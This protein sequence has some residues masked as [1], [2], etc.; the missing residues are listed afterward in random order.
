[1]IREGMAKANNNRAL[2][3][4]TRNVAWN[5]A[6]WGDEQRW[7]NGDHF[8]HRW[9]GGTYQRSSMA[10]KITDR[11]LSPYLAGRYELKILEIAP[12]GGRFTTELIRRA[13]K[14]VLVDLN[15]A[16][17][18]ICRERFKYYNNHAGQ[19]QFHVNDGMSLSMIKER[20]FDLVASYDSMVHMQ[21]DIVRAYLA[22]CVG[23]LA[24]DGIIWIDTSG[25][26]KRRAGFR[27]AVTDKLIK[28]WAR[29]LGLKVLSQTFRNNWDCISVLTKDRRAHA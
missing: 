28:T 25:K 19:I 11:L 22:Q 29:E 1:M 16:C 12:G 7:G 21:P 8:G 17:I 23:L 13:G 20:D 14:L 6:R 24:R 5:T 3:D 9:P 4:K 27:T 10:A 2:T 18:E 26:G 15:E